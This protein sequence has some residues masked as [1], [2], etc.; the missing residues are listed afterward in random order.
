MGTK[1]QIDLIM[2]LYDELRE[3]PKETRK[4]LRKL[5]QEETFKKIKE[6]AVQVQ[7]GTA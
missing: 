2:A 7:K 1:K 4:E 6:L 3:Q 5:T